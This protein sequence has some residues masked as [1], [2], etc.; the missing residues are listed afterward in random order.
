MSVKTTKNTKKDKVLIVERQ[1][2]HTHF[3]EFQRLLLPSGL[4]FKALKVA[5][6]LL[7]HNQFLNHMNPANDIAVCSASLSELCSYFQSSRK[8]MLAVLEALKHPLLEINSID[9][10]SVTYTV[11]TT[12]FRSR[13]VIKD[14]NPNDEAKEAC[15]FINLDEMKPHRSLIGWM[16]NNFKIYFGQQVKLKREFLFD[17]F[18]YD[19]ETEKDRKNAVRVI[20]RA[21]KPQGYT[22][23]NYSFVLAKP[24][25]KQAVEDDYAVQL[26]QLNA[27]SEQEYNLSLYDEVYYGQL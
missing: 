24:M 4:S 2:I 7:H 19:R 16:M 14:D 18:G 25:K 23:Q 22:Y 8:P 20:K 26:S 15:Y 10:F 13:K 3:N 17:L 21:S 5:F 9:N 1:F 12:A 6:Y 27:E 11:D